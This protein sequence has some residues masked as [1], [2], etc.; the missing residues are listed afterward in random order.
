MCFSCIAVLMYRCINVATTL[1]CCPQPVGK[2][3]VSV[4]VIDILIIATTI[5]LSHLTSAGKSVSFVLMW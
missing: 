5:L 1:S 3:Y 4:V 2:K